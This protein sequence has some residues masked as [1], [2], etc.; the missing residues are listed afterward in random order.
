MTA[1]VSTARTLS[2]TLA[3]LEDKAVDSDIGSCVPAGTVI[4]LAATG[5]GALVEGLGVD[6][7]LLGRV[8]AAGGLAFAACCFAR[9]ASSIA[10]SASFSATSAAISASVVAAV[11]ALPQAASRASDPAAARDIS[12]GFFMVELSINA[13]GG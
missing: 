2:P 3:D 4:V 11:S 5:F 10:S 13:A 1:L 8:A 9:S 7:V 6:A 12:K